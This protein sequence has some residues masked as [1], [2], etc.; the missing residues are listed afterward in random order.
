M[1]HAQMTRLAINPDIT[2]VLWVGV[3][4]DN[5]CYNSCV[6]AYQI[7][8]MP[9]CIVLDFWPNMASQ[10]GKPSINNARKLTVISTESRT[11]RTIEVTLFCPSFRFASS[12][13]LLYLSHLHGI[14]L[15]HPRKAILVCRMRTRRDTR[16]G[17]GLADVMN[18]KIYALTG[19]G[20]IYALRHPPTTSS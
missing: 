6:W 13:G 12:T 2:Q 1:N 11:Q 3:L 14:D 7:D 8:C 17:V 10:D 5:A 15:I 18:G 19:D 20:T 9:R 16:G 4:S